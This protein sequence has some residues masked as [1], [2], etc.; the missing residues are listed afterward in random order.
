MLEK[1]LKNLPTEADL[2]LGQIA[3]R[4]QGRPLSDVAFTVREAG[5][6]AVR[7]GRDRIGQEEL[8]RGIEPCSKEHLQA[9]GVDK[10]IGFV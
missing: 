5:R 3:S 7:S 2:D 9:S 4:L 8:M 1:L 6:L 10:S